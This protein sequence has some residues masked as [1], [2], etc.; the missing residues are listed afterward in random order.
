MFSV[1][2][3][4]RYVPEQSHIY[5]VKCFCKP[6]RIYRSE[7][8]RYGITQYPCYEPLC[9]SDD[10]VTFEHFI[11]AQHDADARRRARLMVDDDCRELYGDD[12]YVSVY[13]VRCKLADA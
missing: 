3:D 8:N 11:V 13:Y 1:S 7:P 10:C 2:S 5:L 12:V 6:Y 9:D 4:P